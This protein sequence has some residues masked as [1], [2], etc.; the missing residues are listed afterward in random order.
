[1]LQLTHFFYS[2]TMNLYVIN[3]FVWEKIMGNRVTL[4]EI[5]DALGISRNTVSRALN[6]TGSVS[7][8]TRKKIC[9][10]AQAMGYKQ[11]QMFYP[12]SIQPSDAAE[13]L[14][15]G[16]KNEIALFTHAFPG[17]SHSGAKLLEAFQHKIDTLG[18]RLTINIIRDYEIE[19][20]CLP[21]NF[22]KDKVA[23]ILCIELFSREYSEFLCK[24]DI[25]TLFIDSPLLWTCDLSADILLAESLYNVYQLL[26]DLIKSGNK[27]IA[28]VGDK[29][30]CQSF[31]E[32]WQAY[33]SV[34]TDNGLY[35]GSNLSI[36]DD[37]SAPYSDTKWLCK[38]IQELNE[39][40]DV[41]FCANDFL[42]MSTIKALKALGK[43]VPED[44]LV[45]G[46]DDAPEAAIFDPGLTTIKIPSCS[47][48]YTA[49][50]LLLSRIQNPSAPYRKT[51]IKTEII[52]RESTKG[53]A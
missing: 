49:A 42:A 14:P 2:V 37:D 27:K 33:I 21:N 19:N 7:D 30:H 1:M 11:F 34:L 10:T 41:F 35:S 53:R 12:S 13:A 46:F 5:A 18:Y 43:S 16:K 45:C 39:F 40:P 24:Q 17:N 36:L 25:P 9:Q 38:R 47:M 6:N 50:E 28:Y 31:Y 22:R 44:V 8:E 23:G 48:G 52:K 29:L 20:L 3:L 26:D 4:Q 15:I 51:Y 32:R